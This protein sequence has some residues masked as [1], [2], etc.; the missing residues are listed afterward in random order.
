MKAERIK[1]AHEIDVVFREIENLKALNHP[2]I[3]R[4]FKC[5]TLKDMKVVLVMEYL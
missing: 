5:Y 2:H 3:V 1:S 4:I